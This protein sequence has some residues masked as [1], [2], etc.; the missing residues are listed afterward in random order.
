VKLSQS[1]K[2]EEVRKAFAMAGVEIEVP[3]CI[4]SPPRYFR[5]TVNLVVQ[6]SAQED[7][8]REPSEDQ[9]ERPKRGRSLKVGYY[10][11]LSSL[12]V[13]SISS[14]LVAVPQINNLILKI[15]RVLEEFRELRRLRHI[16][17]KATSQD[18]L[19]LLLAMEGKKKSKKL[20]N[21]EK[22]TEGPFNGQAGGGVSR[23]AT[24]EVC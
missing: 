12:L 11:K 8:C 24:R 16:S 18:G 9:E 1:L 22:E 15:G 6:E 23:G 14:C 3:R 4:P 10:H 19:L 20:P 13:T 7:R 5:S 21:Q 2:E 17:I